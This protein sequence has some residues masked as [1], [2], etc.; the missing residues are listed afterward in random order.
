MTINNFLFLNYLECKYKA[1]LTNRGV[2]AKNNDYI[3]FVNNQRKLMLKT[4]S[5]Q[6]VYETVKLVTL[7]NFLKKANSYYHFKKIEVDDYSLFDITSVQK[8]VF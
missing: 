6:R 3:D 1:Y 5:P 2:I 8:F 4:L 7:P